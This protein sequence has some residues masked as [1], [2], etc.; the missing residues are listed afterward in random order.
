MP[1]RENYIHYSGDHNGNRNRDGDGYSH[2]YCNGNGDRHGH[3]HGHGHDYG[4][5]NR[6]RHG[7][8]YNHGD[9]GDDD[10]VYYV[11]TDHSHRDCD[12]YD[13]RANYGHSG[14]H[15]YTHQLRDVD[16]YDRFNLYVE[17]AND[18]HGYFDSD[19]YRG[20]RDY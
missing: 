3:D 5:G 8:Y 11:R 2:D 19:Y 9:L 13:C 6:N 14:P 4:N 1:D 17:R 15:E 20:L 12:F 10:D 7:H 18:H 16:I